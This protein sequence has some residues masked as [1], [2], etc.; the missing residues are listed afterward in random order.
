MYTM[1]TFRLNRDRAKIS[2]FLSGR[3]EVVSAVLRT[4]E[5]ICLDVR[6]NGDEALIKYAKRFDGVRFSSGSDFLVSPAE[7][8]EA[9][10]EVEGDFLDSLKAARKRI[11]R[12]HLARLNGLKSWRKNV[13]GMMLGERILPIERVGI[14]IPGGRAS[15]P[16][17]V[18]MCAVPAGL[19]GVGQILMCV[20]PAGN[21]K[22]N[23]YTLA[24]ADF[25]GLKRVYKLGG[26]YAIAA[27]AFGTQTIAPVD[28]IVGPGNRYVTA[29]KAVV[30]RFSVGIDMLAGP[31]EI[32]IIADR[33]A[34]ADFIAADILSQA[35][36]GEDSTAI[37]ITDSDSLAME[38]RSCLRRQM[39]SLR[40]REIIRKS[41]QTHGLIIITPT[42]EEAVDVSNEIAPEHLEL[43]VKAPRGMLGKVRNAGAV[44][45]GNFS[46]ESVGDYAAGPNAVLPT[47]GSARFSSGLG[48][49]HFL[50]RIN[51]ISCSRGGLRR[52]SAPALSLARAEGLDAHAEAIRIRDKNNTKEIA[53]E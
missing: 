18:L 15:Y 13:E 31:T 17:T 12:F 16:S 26:A 35:E 39:R 30:S 34:R 52:L 27:L 21:G 42:I 5:K 29:A 46:P 49:H 23:P 51:V 19:A 50:K 25:M 24:A 36:H 10:E 28:K 37:L 32:V 38:V 7:I 6:A 45:L 14:Y 1:R 8:A 48:V 44:F 2:A 22:V 11:K 41:L 20:P 33:L 47:G 3:A 43:Q 4:V 40:R 53:C 9:K